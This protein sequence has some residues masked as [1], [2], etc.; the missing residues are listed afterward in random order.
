MNM[1][2]RKITD[3]ASIIARHVFLPINAIIFV[4]VAL[5]IVFG[6]VRDGIFLG[7][8]VFVNMVL[9]M[10]QDIRAWQTLER[11]Q[12]LTALHAL[13]VNADGSVSDIAFEM[14]Q[15]GDTLRVKLGDQVPCDSI[16]IDADS[17]EISESLITGESDSFTKKEEDQ[18]LG[19]S[20]VTAGRATVRAETSYA[21]GALARMSQGLRRY[22]ANPSPIQRSINTVITYTLAVLIAS[23]AYIVIRGFLVHDS[24]IQMVE[25]VG[26]LASILVPQGLIVSTTLLFT[27]GAVHFL[28]RNVLLQE[29]N[30][31]EKF[32]RIKHLCM[33]KTGTLTENVLTVEAVH[34]SPGESEGHARE[35]MSTYIRGSHDTSQTI[36]AVGSFIGMQTDAAILAAVAFSSWRG[37]GGIRT[38]G[39]IVLVGSSDAFVDHLSESGNK[40]WFED[41][42][43]QYASAGKRTLSVVR[44]D[45]QEIPKSLEPG[46][47]LTAVALF[48][49]QQELREGIRDTVDFFQQRGVCIRVLSGDNP[50][51]VQA[52]ARGAGIAGSDGVI[53]GA[54]LDALDDAGFRSA[55]EK[56]RIFARIQPRQKE[57]VIGILKEDGF[58]AM[59]GDGAN[60]ALSVKNADLGIAMFDGAPATRQ[61]AG[62]VLMNNSLI[63]LPAGV[64]LADSM[65]ENIE[66]YA[67]IFLNQTFV[68]FLLFMAL[69]I[70]GYSFPFTP[71]NVS[72]ITFFAVGV[73]YMLISYWAIR[74][75]AHTMPVSTRPFLRRVLPFPVTLSV[76]EAV[77]AFLICMRGT[78]VLGGDA[79]RM[80]LML[81]FMFLGYG[82]FILTPAVYSGVTSTL[83]KIQLAGLGVVEVI[84][85]F[86]F[87]KAPILMMLYNATEPSYAAVSLAFSAAVVCT[88]VLYVL[89]RQFF[90]IKRS[91]A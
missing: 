64:R 12:L 75:T 52:I 54:E 88:A 8:V 6:S 3:I 51:T 16:V 30:A 38:E 44:L 50:A 81:L 46:M 79:L 53:T 26:A 40:K 42:V 10:A 48:V 17:L 85:V 43:A 25:T 49:L 58:T 32:G 33:D 91:V 71:L 69:S 61:V 73:P 1:D 63:E 76:V 29:V 68:G 7:A 14:V 74:P 86:L 22:T 11:L 80:C 37:Y 78:E 59:V 57:R 87:F 15:K 2:R 9:G 77:A 28:N 34:V 18:L 13:R 65:I 83:Q 47:K 39:G 60:D 70:A 89:A 36:I 84:L 21:E 41:T 27:F 4:V 56:Y 90:W 19:G 5:L 72:L 67:S 31:T 66:I 82:F 23:I 45:A 62:V 24:G 20:V 35:L 55:V